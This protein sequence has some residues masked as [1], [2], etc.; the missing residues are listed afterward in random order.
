MAE[1][2][3]LPSSSA[4]FE[5]LLDHAMLTAKIPTPRHPRPAGKRPFL[6]KGQGLARFNMPSA[7]AMKASSLSDSSTTPPAVQAEAEAETPSSRSQSA[8]SWLTAAT[9]T[10]HSN[11][12]ATV[13]KTF[14]RPLSKPGLQ[15][16]QRSPGGPRTTMSAKGGGVAASEMSEISFHMTP[17]QW[18]H[19]KHDEEQ[20]LHEF[21]LLEEVAAQCSVASSH[22]A[23]PRQVA[24]VPDAKLARVSRWAEEQLPTSSATESDGDHSMNSTLDDDNDNANPSFGTSGSQASENSPRLASVDPEATPTRA[25][26]SFNDTNAWDTAVPRPPSVNGKQI[27][28]PTLASTSSSE[29]GCSG[30]PRDA[31]VARLFGGVKNKLAVRKA[32]APIAV[33]PVPSPSKRDAT[34]Q[35]KLAEL[36]QEIARYRSLNSSLKK[37]QQE[38]EAGLHQLQT[39]I[40]DFQRQRDEEKQAFE[41]Y[42]EDTLQKLKKEKRVWESYRVNV[43]ERPSKRDREEVDALR[44]ELAALR[45]EM[46]IRETKAA[47]ATRRAK[48]RVQTLTDRNH[49]LEQEVRALEQLRLEAWEDSSTG[50][51][52]PHPVQPNLGHQLSRSAWE[53]GKLHAPSPTKGTV[54]LPEENILPS[55]Q[56][57]RRSSGGHASHPRQLPAAAP[58]SRADIPSQKLLGPNSSSLRPAPQGNREPQSGQQNKIV[59]PLI[60]RA[61]GDAANNDIQA[62]SFSNGTVK[63]LHPDGSVVVRYFNGDIKQTK[64]GK[65]I[66]FYAESGTTHITCDGLETTEFANGQI[67]LQWADGRREIRFPDQTI[68]YL[69]PNAEEKVVFPDGTV[70]QVRKDLLAAY[71]LFV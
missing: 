52:H 40:R 18:E 62:V 43:A 71:F 21:Q 42:K 56:N 35:T 51:D 15:I 7:R 45:K 37:L 38:R 39:E 12:M 66:Y 23:S 24:G 61:N 55:W 19:I 41:S 44:S 60:A 11:G 16:E 50:S 26:Q 49:E 13:R 46:E 8:S 10:N 2:L 48:D 25:G 34:A 30:P 59:S 70:Q 17:Q 28:P 3:P 36:D 63:E 68:K 47:M 6:R 64:A 65:I 1:D 69:F 67:E 53:R 58:L 33:T 29:G 22:E 31:L 54:V 32:T 27:P 57:D 20:S 9:S 14:Y 4:S 5:T